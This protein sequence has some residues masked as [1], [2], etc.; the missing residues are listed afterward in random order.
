MLWMSKG[1][2]QTHCIDIFVRNRHGYK[3]RGLGALKTSYP[4][5]ALAC[6]SKLLSTPAGRCELSRLQ[7]AATRYSSHHLAVGDVDL[8][9]C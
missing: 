9:Y 7:P 4:A 3:L 2:D 8:L 6:V 5:A 1:A